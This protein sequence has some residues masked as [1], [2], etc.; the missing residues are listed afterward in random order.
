MLGYLT[1]ILLL[2]FGIQIVR[3]SYIEG[4][5]RWD[6]TNIFS[7]RMIS[8]GQMVEI[9]EES[10]LWTQSA[11]DII[12][13]IDA[14]SSF[15]LKF[16]IENVGGSRREMTVSTLKTCIFVRKRRWGFWGE[17]FQMLEIREKILHKVMVIVPRYESADQGLNPVPGSQHAAD[18]PV[19][20]H[21]WA[22]WSTGTCGNLGKVNCCSPGLYTGPCPGVMDSSHLRLKGEEQW[23]WALQPCAF[24]VYAPS[25]TYLTLP[26]ML[27]K[28]TE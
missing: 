21:F 26:W 20:L 19:H 11:S 28:S 23:R 6:N 5:I 3:E 12:V 10:N 7:D 14:A 4:R 22:G 8:L 13:H 25:F 9:F 24:I 1:I 27:Q 16:R 15:G 18:P 2:H 17:M